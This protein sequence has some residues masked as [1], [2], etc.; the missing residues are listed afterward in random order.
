MQFP[1]LMDMTPVLDQTIFV[2]GSNLLGVHGAGAARYARDYLLAEDGV[3]EGPTGRA[4]AL[5]T[6]AAPINMLPPDMELLAAAVKRFLEYAHMHPEKTFQVTA[7][8]CGLAGFSHAEVAPLFAGAPDNCLLP[9]V[10]LQLL[11]RLPQPR[12]IIAGSRDIPE[13]KALGII[14]DRLSK[15][16][17]WHVVSGTA[18]GVD[19]AGEVYAE[20]KR[21]PITCFSA[22]WDRFGKRAGLLR[23][24]TMSWFG[25]HLLALWDG[26]SRGTANMIEVASRDGLKVKVIQVG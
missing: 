5:P 20:R 24:Q 25:T 19:R 2:F 15:Q 16:K 1:E 26:N 21:F 3:G 13:E 23:N 22:N 17:R 6:K 4:Y 18:R 14:T 11:E 9:G 8:G 10:W 7:V 12:V